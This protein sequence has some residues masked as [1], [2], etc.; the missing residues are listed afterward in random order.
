MKSTTRSKFTRSNMQAAL[1]NVY[2][3]STTVL[4]HF[5]KYEYK[6]LK[7]LIENKVSELS[8]FDKH[9][10]NLL[11]DKILNDERCWINQPE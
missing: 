11:S 6:L 1:S 9:Q 4:L 5:T 8:K 10:L 3:V 7:T 2:D